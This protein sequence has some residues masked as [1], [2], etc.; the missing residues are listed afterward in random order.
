M[1]LDREI[2]RALSRAEGFN[3][4]QVYC[5]AAG[6]QTG[7]P[8]SMDPIKNNF[9]NSQFVFDVGYLPSYLPT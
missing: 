5:F 2:W 7:R 6:W 3:N 8:V 4:K 1:S 9:F